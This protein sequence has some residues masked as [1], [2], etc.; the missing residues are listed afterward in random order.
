VEGGKW[1]EGVHRG[2]V[3]RC[4]GYPIIMGGMDVVECVEGHLYMPNQRFVVVQQQERMD[5]HKIRTSGARE[6]ANTSNQALLGFF[7]MFQS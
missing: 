3:L 1:M 6:P 5:C 7:T 4:K 2:N